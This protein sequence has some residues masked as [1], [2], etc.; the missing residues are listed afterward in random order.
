MHGEFV[1]YIGEAEFHLK[2]PRSLERADLYAIRTIRS[3]C[4]PAVQPPWFFSLQL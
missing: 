3:S 2:S 4:T 1:V